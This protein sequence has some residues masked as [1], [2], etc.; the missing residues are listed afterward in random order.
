MN[1]QNFNLE[2]LTEIAEKAQRAFNYLSA[3]KEIADK[4]EQN[5]TPILLTQKEAANILQVSVGHLAVLRSDKKRA[6]RLKY[7]KLGG[8]VYYKLQH[9]FDYIDARTYQSTD[10]EPDIKKKKK[11]NTEDISQ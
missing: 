9:L 5:K 1:L 2:S 6:P 8:S 7:I 3:L 10:E 11:K 4:G